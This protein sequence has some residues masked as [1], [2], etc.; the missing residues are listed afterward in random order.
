M[1]T[2]LTSVALAAALLAAPAHAAPRHRGPQSGVATVT[3]YCSDCSGS[4]GCRGQ[5]LHVGDVAADPRYHPFGS[6]V[7]IDGFG[8]LTVRDTGGAIKGAHRFDIYRGVFAK[9]QCGTKVGRQ[10]RHWE[11]VQ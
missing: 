2:A 3:A 6:R 9:C 11:A 1:R 5:R 4:T 8:T 7:R 10:R